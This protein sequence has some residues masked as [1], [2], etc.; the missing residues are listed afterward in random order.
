MR[1]GWLVT[2]HSES[3]R[4]RGDWGPQSHMLPGIQPAIR[5]T[6]ACSLLKPLLCFLRPPSDI[7][8]VGGTEAQYPGCLVH[9][10][11]TSDWNRQHRAGFGSWALG[12]L[13][14]V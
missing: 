14:S 1:T 10:N 2:A 13:P 9:M 12:Q 7:A 6:K 3:L 11:N 4:A 5:P 8:H